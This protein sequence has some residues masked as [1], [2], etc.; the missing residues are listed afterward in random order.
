[1]R[2]LLSTALFVAATSSLCLT[3]NTDGKPLPILD[4]HV[5]AIDIDSS[6]LGIG[7]MC[8]NTSKFLAS[9]P[10][11]KEAP[12]GWVTESCTPALYPAQKGRIS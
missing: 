4:V 1:M 9:D 10:K 6:T 11:T 2:T 7:P 12:F 8:P 5:H 3:Q